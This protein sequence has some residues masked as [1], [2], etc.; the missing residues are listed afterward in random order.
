MFPDGD[1]CQYA[2]NII[3]EVDANDH[4]T[5]LLKKIADHCKSPTIIMID[6]KFVISKAGRKI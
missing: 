1:I 3:S 6:D 2:A 5:L 4:H